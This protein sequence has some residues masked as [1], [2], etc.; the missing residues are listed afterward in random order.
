MLPIL[1]II[2]KWG[3][4]IALCLSIAANWWLLSELTS[5]RASLAVANANLT[6]MEKLRQQSEVLNATT[7][8]YV[9]EIQNLRRER[10][11][12]RRAMQT[13]RK[14]DSAYKAWADSPLPDFVVRKYRRLQQQ[15]ANSE[16]R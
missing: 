15:D 14:T 16:A 7:E 12:L 2:L 5:T 4:G 3:A 6:E 13:A 1:T 9:N 8:S 10:D 11:G